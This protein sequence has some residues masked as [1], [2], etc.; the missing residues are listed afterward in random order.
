MKQIIVIVME[1]II[2]ALYGKMAKYIYIFI[3]I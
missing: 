2:K 1:I 3:Y